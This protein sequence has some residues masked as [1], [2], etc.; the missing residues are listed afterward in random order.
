MTNAAIS[1]ALTG[2]LPSPPFR[3]QPVTG[4]GV[5]PERREQ[6]EHDRDGHHVF[7]DHGV[8]SSPS[9]RSGAL[10]WQALPCR[11]P[12]VPVTIAQCPAMASTAMLSSSTFTC[13]SP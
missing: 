9:G 2:G 10:P 8:T 4:A 1:T 6:R 12:A 5:Q 13:G 11:G 3:L 7:A